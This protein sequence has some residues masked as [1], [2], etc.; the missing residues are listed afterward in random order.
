MQGFSV[1]RDRCILCGQCIAACAKKVLQDNGDGG[2]LL[3]A[4]KLPQCNACGHCGAVCPVGAVV[5]PNCGGEAAVP[6]EPSLAVPY[7]QARQFLLSCRSI[8]SFKQEEVARD[9]ILALLDVARRAPTSSNAQPIRWLVVSGRDKARRVSELVIEWF[10]TVVRNDPTLIGNYNLDALV[11]GFRGGYD[12]ILRGA[13]NLVCAITDKSHGR[14]VVDASIAL[15]YFCLAAHGKNIGSCWAGF[16]MRC[17]ATYAPLR[18]Y[19]R[20]D[21]DSV[22]HAAAFFGYPDISYNALPPRKPLRADWL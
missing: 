5:S 14:G 12:V 2:P 21:D 3:T 22:A 9:E 20:L 6:L 4:E 13:P 15:T 19:L 10:D 1:D 7:E 8:R 17:A 16:V 11:G 18:A